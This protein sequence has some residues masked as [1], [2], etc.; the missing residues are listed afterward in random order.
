MDGRIG[1]DS[2]VGAG[3]RFFEPPLAPAVGTDHHL[4][5]VEELPTGLRVLV[6]DDN[7]TNRLVLAAQLHS[8]NLTPMSW[9]T[10]GQRSPHCTMRSGTAGRTMPRSS[11]WAC[12]S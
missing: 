5:P 6:V 12:P 3:N 1:L 10:A 9:W 11:T 4:P 7:A 2:D 8:W